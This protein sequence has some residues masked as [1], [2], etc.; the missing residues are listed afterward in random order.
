MDQSNPSCRPRSNWPTTACVSRSDSVAY[1]T[2]PPKGIDAFGSGRINL[3]I[4]EIPVHKDVLLTLCL[5]LSVGMG[6]ILVSRRLGLPTIVLLLA[7][8]FAMGPEGLGLVLPDS[9]GPFLPVVVSLSVALILFEG[10]LTLDLHGYFQG[11]KVIRRLLSIGVIVTWLG[12]A[13]RSGCSLMSRSLFHSWCP[14]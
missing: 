1:A 11:S 12:G 14:V 8:G 7:G 9:L 3:K 2:A 13:L 5:A 10:G 6:L 4:L